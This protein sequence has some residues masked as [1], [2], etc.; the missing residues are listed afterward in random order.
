MSASLWILVLDFLIK[1][2]NHPYLY[3]LGYLN[4]QLVLLTG[5]LK[6]N[7]S[8]LS[9]KGLLLRSHNVRFETLG[10]I[11]RLIFIDQY[12]EEVIASTELWE[13]EKVNRSL[14]KKYMGIPVC[15]I[16]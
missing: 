3:S 15:L 2:L 16:K 6:N 10:V 1:R 5:K 12:V 9:S 8:E 14:M 4:D 13:S 11:S 7:M